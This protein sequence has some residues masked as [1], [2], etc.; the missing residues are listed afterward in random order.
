MKAT[1]A[2][3]RVG[4]VVLAA[5][6]SRRMGG[7]NKLLA[8]FDGEPLVARAVDA[9]LASRARPV[10]VVTGHEAARVRARRSPAAT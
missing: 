6:L 2:S 10:V 5:G 8:E 3:R 1:P 9:V 4:A 7:A